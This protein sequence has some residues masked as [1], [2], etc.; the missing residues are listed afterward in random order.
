MKAHLM[1]IC[2]ALAALFN[3]QADV[4]L[5]WTVE[6]S[7]VNPVSFDAYH[8]ETLTLTAS[9]KSYGVAID[10]TG[11]TANIFWRTPSM[12]N[13]VYW[14]A[15]ASCAGNVITATFDGS[16]DPGEPRVYGF[17]GI[18]G[19]SY[20]ASFVLRL[21]QSPGFTPG[22]VSLPTSFLDFERLTVANAP[23]FTREETAG[24]I[25][26]IVTKEFVEGLGIA[27]GGGGFPT[28][29]DGDVNVAMTDARDD[30][31]PYK[32]NFNGIGGNSLLGIDAGYDFG[33]V[34]IGGTLHVNG[35]AAL[36]IESGSIVSI[37]G[38]RT[39]GEFGLEGAAE[40]IANGIPAVVTNAVREVL[41][42]VYDPTLKVT[43]KIV[44]DGGHLYSVA[45]TNVDTTVL[46]R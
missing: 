33:G 37:Q 23:Y 42:T 39:F 34:F 31:T 7:R 15:P 17:L 16:M 20:R 21:M 41:N 8:G 45:Y 18:Q 6:T 26:N 36:E 11:K 29:L 24:E 25:T 3:C 32:I 43:W 46:G 1:T 28:Q 19:E 4:P 40:G 12:T 22:T 14:I 38:A 27:G 44:M 13:G 35:D 5:K 10:L 30:E 2:T 9:L